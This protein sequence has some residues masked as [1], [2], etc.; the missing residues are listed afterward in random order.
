MRV[1]ASPGVTADAGRPDADPPFARNPEVY[2]VGDLPRAPLAAAGP[3]GEPR[4]LQRGGVPGSDGAA[5]GWHVPPLARAA[6][7]WVRGGCSCARRCDPRPHPGGAPPAAVG[8]GFR[9]SLGLRKPPEAHT[10]DRVVRKPRRPERWAL[11]LPGRAA[12]T[13]CLIGGGQPRRPCAGQ[14]RSLLPACGVWGQDF[15]RLWLREGPARPSSQPR[16]HTSFRPR[17][18]VWARSRGGCLSLV[19][20]FEFK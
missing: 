3:T 5:G 16:V 2:R 8:P 18:P 9:V 6:C 15:R 17:E 11:P 10:A 12:S 4:W 7:L 14:R 20:R 19:P 1:A 13:V